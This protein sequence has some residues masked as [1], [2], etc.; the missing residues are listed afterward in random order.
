MTTPTT[1]NKRV[2]AAGVA[3]A[4]ALMVLLPPRAFVQDGWRT[5]NLPPGPAGPQT[6]G[7]VHP[8]LDGALNRIYGLYLREGLAGVKDHIAARKRIDAEG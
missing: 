7:P 4:A 1:R 3:C 6:P 8:R 5:A 2:L